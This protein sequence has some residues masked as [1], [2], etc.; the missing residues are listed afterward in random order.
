MAW[1]I[2][3]TT[4]ANTNDGCGV[5]STSMVCSSECT[6]FD[7]VSSPSLRPCVAVDRKNLEVQAA[8]RIPR[9]A[10]GLEQPP[11]F[12]SVVTPM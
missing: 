12:T 7:M 11:T 4:V 3:K 9:P 2:W 6:R 1:A 10:M 5:H 8:S